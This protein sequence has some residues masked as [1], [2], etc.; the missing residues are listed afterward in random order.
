[1]K[2][3]TNKTKPK[4]GIWIKVITHDIKIF[5]MIIAPEGSKHLQAEECN[6]SEWKQDIMLWQ[7]APQFDT[8]MRKRLHVGPFRVIRTKKE[9]K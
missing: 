9:S 3:Y 1:M 8:L 5:D 6:W 4:C 7:Y 2:F